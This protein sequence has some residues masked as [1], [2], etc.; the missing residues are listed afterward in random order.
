M[1][2]IPK[3]LIIESA[4]LWLNHHFE[5]KHATAILSIF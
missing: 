2:D 4:N 1:S 3:M 5:P